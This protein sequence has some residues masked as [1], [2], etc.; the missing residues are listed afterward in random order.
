MRVGPQFFPNLPF[1]VSLERKHVSKCVDMVIKTVNYFTLILS[2]L[3]K[4]SLPC[5]ITKNLR[6]I[7]NETNHPPFDTSIHV[8]YNDTC[9]IPA[10]QSAR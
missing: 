6:L 1:C 9:E 8:Y 2:Q 10:L 5:L 7:N 4:L 3:S